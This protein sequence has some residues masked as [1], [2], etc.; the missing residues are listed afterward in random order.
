MW[1]HSQ[2]LTFPDIALTVV[3]ADDFALRGGG[4]GRGKG[5]ETQQW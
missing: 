5:A 3:V 2:I 4:S 1:K